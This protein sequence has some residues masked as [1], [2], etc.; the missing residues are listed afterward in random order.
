MPS[1]LHRSGLGLWLSAKDLS[2]LSD[3]AGVSAW[4]NRRLNSI[5]GATSF[6]QAVGANQPAKQTVN[7][8]TVVRFSQAGADFV[9]AT[10]NDRL[11]LTADSSV[12]VVAKAAAHPGTLNSLL[13]KSDAGNPAAYYFATTNAG[14]P[15]LD[16]PF[17]E[18]GVASTNS[19]GTTNP[20][21]LGCIVKGTLVSH[22][23]DGAANGTD[24]LAGGTATNTDLSIGRFSAAAPNYWDGDLYEILVFN[25]AVSAAERK[26][27]T[28]Y[29]G[30][31][32]G[33]TV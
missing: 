11:E 18:A 3:G 4:A 12:F 8:R 31:E 23:L 32:H 33:I 17:V 26:G 1:L 19:M 7:G 5:R 15:V 21:I 22:F 29:L 28:R 9:A 16:R 30:R 27:I 13:A 24:T 10:D 20:R 6:A 14:N 25:R 2:A